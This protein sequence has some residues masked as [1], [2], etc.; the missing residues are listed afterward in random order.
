MT[1]P[2]KAKRGS[3]SSQRED[4]GALIP[5]LAR[6]HCQVQMRI[7]KRIRI[8]ED[9]VDMIGRE[10]APQNEKSKKR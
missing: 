4:L 3:G 10:I 7:L 8:L 9:L 1:K 6:Q 5:Q 2:Q